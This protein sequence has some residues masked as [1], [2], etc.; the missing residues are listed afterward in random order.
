MLVLFLAVTKIIHLLTTIVA[1]QLIPYLG[2]F[3]YVKDLAYFRLPPFISAWANFDGLY[4][5]RIAQQGYQQYE[6]AFFPLYPLLIRFL[7]P[8]F[9]GNSLL[10]GIFISNLSFLLAIWI[11]HKFLR[12]SKQKNLFLTLIILLIF[13]TAFFFGAVYTESLFLLLVVL[14]F[15]LLKKGSFLLATIVTYFAALTRL[16][17]IFLILPLLINLLTTHPRRSWFYWPL[18]LMPVLG[19]LTYMVYLYL[20]TGNWLAFFHAQSVFGEARSTTLIFLPQVYYRY[21]KIFITA[22]WNFQYFVSLVEVITFSG[23]LG[24]LLLDLRIQIQKQDFP[25]IALNLFSLANIL[26]PTLTGSFM[27]IPRF[28]LLSLSF[29]VCLSQIKSK[30]AL[31]LLISFFAVLQLILLSFFIQGYFIS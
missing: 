7:T 21:F 4:Y 11:L 13:P 6:Q 27:S 23:V 18:L 5:L 31:S 8:L 19:L 17:G 24:V 15:Y 9:F 25:L 1:P 12:L 3:A 14:T 16:V 29:F 28:A 2:S 30:L 26:L 22:A 10:T 20:S